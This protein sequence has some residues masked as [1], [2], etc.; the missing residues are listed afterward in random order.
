MPFYLF[1]K[2]DGLHEHDVV[3]DTYIRVQ[4]RANTSL[5]YLLIKS[6]TQN[7]KKLMLTA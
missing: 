6:E 1:M 4:M 5:N 3:F 2:Y 7:M